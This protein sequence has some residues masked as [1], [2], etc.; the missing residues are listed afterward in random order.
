MIDVLWNVFILTMYIIDIKAFF[1]EQIVHT[2]F[3]KK[4][5]YVKATV[6]GFSSWKVEN[7][8][9][10]GRGLDRH[11]S[12]VEY[13]K[14]DGVHS[15]KIRRSRTDD[16]G[17]VVYI[18]IMEL[19]MACRIGYEMPYYNVKDWISIL[20]PFVVTLIFLIRIVTG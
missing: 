13:E 9:V 8:M 14:G 20:F 12:I 15:E 6:K 18:D 16:V 3:K 11:Y 7:N 19:G 4:D 2:L 17:K 1:G 5:T 10:D